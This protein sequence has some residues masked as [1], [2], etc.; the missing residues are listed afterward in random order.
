MEFDEAHEIMRLMRRLSM[1]QRARKTE[2]L[3]PLGLQPGQDVV[4]MELA[5]AGSASQNEL[6]QLA[7]VDEPSV[8]RS[9]ARLEKRG[10]IA[11][12]QDPDDSRRRLV[13]LTDG[14]HALIPEI[15][16]IYE[17]V[18]TDAVGD[19]DNLPWLVGHLTEVASRLGL[20][21]VTPP[22]RP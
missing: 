6:A 22:T 5:L 18:A 19:F 9:I 13:T 20:A 3:R 21:P 8:G 14:G 16:E 15:R 11:R 12:T 17:Q 4:L 10:L 2:L 1:A 7:E